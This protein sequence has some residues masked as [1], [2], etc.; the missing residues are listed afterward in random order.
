MR[1]VVLVLGSLSIAGILTI[2]T[3]SIA[4]RVSNIDYEKGW[5]LT[6]SRYSTDGVNGP[7]VYVSSPS[8]DPINLTLNYLF[9]LF[10][11]ALLVGFTLKM[12]GSSVK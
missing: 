6:T 1:R 11:A 7:I 12:R 10:I 4:R 3:A 5:P 8:P 9:Y 2:A